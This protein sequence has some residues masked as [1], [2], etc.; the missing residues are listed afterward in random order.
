MGSLFERGKVLFELKRYDLAASEFV[1]ELGDGPSQPLVFAMLAATQVNLKRF[2]DAEKS[3]RSAIALAPDFAYPHYVRS[4]ILQ[5]RRRWREAEDAV[6]EAIRLEP[7]CDFFHQLAAIAAS[8]NKTSEALS[9]VDHALQLNPLHNPSILLKGN[10]LARAGQLR[11]AHALFQTAISNNP[12]DAAAQHALGSSHLQSGNAS[13]AL[14]LLREARRL[15]PVTAND[16]AA[17][18]LAYGYMIWPLRWLNVCTVRIWQWSHKQRWALFATSAAAFALVGREVGLSSGRKSDFVDYWVWF[19]IV[20]VS[21]FVFPIMLD[22]A[23]NLLGTS[24]LRREF[25]IPWRWM[26][27]SPLLFFR[28]AWSYASILTGAILI[29]I[30]PTL[31]II[32]CQFGAAFPLLAASAKTGTGREMGLLCLPVLVLLM[33]LGCYSAVLTNFQGSFIGVALL[34]VFFLIT[35]FCDTIADRIVSWRF[36][37]SSLYID[38]SR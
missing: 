30:E 21:F 31:G 5:H 13:Q 29:G 10:L 18:A 38:A 28:S 37:R 17:I 8:R 35:L 32:A 3:V 2:A 33:A 1:S 9:A 27:L 23:A 6:R 25:S 34:V 36:R 14:D 7:Q 12:E 4:F 16:S 11:E 15:D 24:L 20:A 19:C 26:I 22:R